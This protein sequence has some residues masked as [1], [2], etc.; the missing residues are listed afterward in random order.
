MIV[1]LLNKTLQFK[2]DRFEPLILRIVRAGFV[3]RKKR[4]M[5]INSSEIERLNGL[6][7]ELGFKFPDLWDPSFLAML[8]PNSSVILQERVEQEKTRDKL[9]IAEIDKKSHNIQLLS[10]QFMA[11]SLE[12]NRQKAGYDFEKLLNQ[13]F[14]LNDLSPRAPFKVTGEQIDGSFVLYNEV[15]LLEA[16]WEKHPSIEADLL[17]FRG[18]IEGKS[19]FTRGVFISVNGI[20]GDAEKSI[21]QGKQPCFYVIN[22]YDILMVLREEVPLSK[23]LFERQRILAEEGRVVVPFRELRF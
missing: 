16:K 2:K 17:V 14:Q 21:T 15:Y 12:N 23:F 18:K 10:E 11:M 13:L 7:L 4:E 3:Y 5:P 1:E 22:G 6:L 20:T 19:Q 9:K 8:E